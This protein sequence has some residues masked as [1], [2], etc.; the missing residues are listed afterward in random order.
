VQR[1]QLRTRLDAEL[2]DQQPP[3]GREDVE[4][5]GLAAGAVQR[6][7]QLPTQALAQRVLGDQRLELRGDLAV[8]AQSQPRLHVVLEGGD[9]L[10][11]QA[12]DRLLGPR[13]VAQVGE[14]RAA[15]QRQR[16][17]QHVGGVLRAGRLP[18]AGRQLLE[19]RDVQLLGTD[20]RHVARA[21]GDDHRR[22]RPVGLDRLA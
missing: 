20:P 11:L 19:A 22:P 10:L 17:G 6:E 21:H 4:R 9:P 18:R 13:L 3:A 1:A 8:T 2:I 7:H 16:L 14:R 12:P 5:L 15:P